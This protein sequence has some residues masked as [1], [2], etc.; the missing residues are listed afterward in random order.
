[1]R[2]TR[3]HIGDLRSP[4]SSNPRPGLL[5]GL[6]VIAIESRRTYRR[7]LP[8]P[9]IEQLALFVLDTIVLKLTLYGLPMGHVVVI[10][11]QERLAGG[12]RRL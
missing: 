2:L 4:S 9:Q 11:R 1:M 5:S 10:P 6:P 3:I 12:R 8:H 7:P